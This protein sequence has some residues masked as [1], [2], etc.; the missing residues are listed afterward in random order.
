MTLDQDDLS[1]YDTE[2]GQYLVEKGAYEILVGPS[3]EDSRLLKTSLL[4]R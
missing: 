2:D 1:F 4:V 3:S